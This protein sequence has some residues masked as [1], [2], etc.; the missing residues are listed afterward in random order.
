MGYLHD[1]IMLN[2]CKQESRAVARKPRDAAAVLFCLKFADNVHYNFKSSQPSKAT[3]E[4]QTYRRKTEFNAKSPFK[5][6]Q[7]HL[8]WSQWKGDKGLSNTKY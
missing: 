6:I 8:F 5:V 7:G 3:L 4:L 1:T 2:V